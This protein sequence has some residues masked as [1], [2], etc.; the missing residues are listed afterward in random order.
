MRLRIR[1]VPRTWI[2]SFQCHGRQVPRPGCLPACL[3]AT[4]LL[5]G[6]GLRG[7]RTVTAVGAGSGPRPWND[8][9]RPSLP[10]KLCSSAHRLP[11]MDKGA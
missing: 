6:K 1:Y 11:R 8:G 2:G 5:L 7:I 4:N 3:P 9:S 10:W